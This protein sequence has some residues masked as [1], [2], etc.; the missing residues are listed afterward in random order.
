LAS[1]EER[2]RTWR[3]EPEATSPSGGHLPPEVDSTGLLDPLF[4]PLPSDQ[5]VD[6]GTR[7]APQHL[8]QTSGTA[9]RPPA[10]IAAPPAVPA[11]TRRV[12]K[13][14]PTVRR[15]RRTLKRVSPL[16][17][18]K[19]S[20]FYYTI[21]LFVWL[22]FVAVVFWMVQSTGAFDAW[23]EVSD[24]FF[25][26]WKDVEITLSLV[27]KWALFIGI[28]GVIVGSIINAFLAFL[29]NLGADILGGLEVTF[30]ERDL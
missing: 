28:V 2:P 3:A 12:P 9:T 4:D 6:G 16:S 13:S 25:K 10:D 1:R 18:L 29:Y 27:E 15:V 21:F 30:V 8:R 7:P 26:Q 20:L 22:G 24:I 11:R 5:S 14:R 17:V 23:N 19:L